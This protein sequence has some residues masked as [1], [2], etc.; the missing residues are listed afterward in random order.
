MSA[1]RMWLTH[2]TPV[3]SKD[4]ITSYGM[5]KSINERWI[6]FGY[7]LRRTSTLGSYRLVFPSSS[8]SNLRSISYPN[9]TRTVIFIKKQCKLYKYTH[10]QLHYENTLCLYHYL[11]TRLLLVTLFRWWVIITCCC[12]PTRDQRT[13][14]GCWEQ[15]QRTWRE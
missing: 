4:K 3:L 1:Q 13:G 8:I 6:K 5:T 15:S 9:P 2:S 14:W 7:F 10:R 11:S 12:A